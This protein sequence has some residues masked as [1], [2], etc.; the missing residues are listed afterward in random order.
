MGAG[1]DLR[2]DDFFIRESAEV[3]VVGLQVWRELAV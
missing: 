3:P 2:R 1:L